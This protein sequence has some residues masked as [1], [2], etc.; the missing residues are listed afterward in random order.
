ME[1]TA[2]TQTAAAA[3]HSPMR[4]EMPTGLRLRCG[5]TPLPSPPDLRAQVAGA[6]VG[7][8]P[9]V[10]GAHGGE[11]RRPR[12]RLELLDAA[13]TMRASRRAHRD[14]SVTQ[15]DGVERMYTAPTSCARSTA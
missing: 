10:R 14:L 11:Y 6:A 3:V 7:A 8:S 5:A 15:A 4:C 12:G 13:V 1:T 9:H 2:V